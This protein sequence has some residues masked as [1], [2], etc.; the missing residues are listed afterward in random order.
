MK[1][2]Y[3]IPTLADSMTLPGGIALRVCDDTQEFVVHSFTT[4][5][6]TGKSRG[7]FQGSYFTHDGTSRA[8]SDAFA[9]ALEEFTRRVRKAAFYDTGGALDIDKLL[10]KEVQAS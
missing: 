4:D 7:Y 10:G 3:E 8:R 2:L 9:D 1:T 6:E 5:R